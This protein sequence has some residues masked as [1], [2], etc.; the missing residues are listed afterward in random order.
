MS[1]NNNNYYYNILLLATFVF[2]D[3]QVQSG[4]SRQREQGEEED[5]GIRRKEKDRSW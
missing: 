1:K 4:M 5:E 2:P 3:L